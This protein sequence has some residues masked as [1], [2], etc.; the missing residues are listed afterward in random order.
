MKWWQIKE[1]ASSTEFW[2]FLRL[3]DGDWWHIGSSSR[4]KQKEKSAVITVFG[5]FTMYPDLVSSR[6]GPNTQAVKVSANHNSDRTSTICSQCPSISYLTLGLKCLGADPWRTRRSSSVLQLPGYSN[7]LS[8]SEAAS[9][10]VNNCTSVFRSVNH[11]ASYWLPRYANTVRAI[12]PPNRLFYS[13]DATVVP[14]FYLFTEP[15]RTMHH[16]RPIRASQRRFDGRI[17]YRS[18]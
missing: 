17:T 2:V 1:D 7:R 3:L 15:G 4:G 18:L 14:R 10:R 5:H 8:A 9:L 6:P 13:T 16:D 11:Y 12:R